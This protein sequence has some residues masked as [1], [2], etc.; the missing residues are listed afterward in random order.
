MNP[1]ERPRLLRAEVALRSSLSRLDKIHVKRLEL[2][3]AFAD[4]R[5]QLDA[6]GGATVGSA[7]SPKLSAL[8]HDLNTARSKEGSRLR[9]VI[10]TQ[11]VTAHHKV[12]E[13]VLVWVCVPAGV[14]NRVYHP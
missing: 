5:K 4:V 1:H 12:Q 7:L 3:T 6:G 8:R 9:A 10:F 14:C 11:S 13:C 2:N